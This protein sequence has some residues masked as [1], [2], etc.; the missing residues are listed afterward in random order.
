M[1]DLANPVTK[2]GATIDASVVEVPGDPPRFDQVQ[3]V[4]HGSID[5]HTYPSSVSKTQRG[6]YVYVPPDYYSSAG[7]A[8]PGALPLAR[9]R[10]RRAGLEPGR[11]RGRD[12]R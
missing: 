8:V 5:I 11:P 1:I 9:R 3:E 4:P 6:L 12:P 7:Q 10:G 2:V